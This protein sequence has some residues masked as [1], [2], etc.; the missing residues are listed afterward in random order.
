MKRALAI[1]LLLG[2]PSVCPGTVLESDPPAALTIVEPV[3]LAASSFVTV[4]NGRSI[5][6]RSLFW[7]CLGMAIG[8]MTLASST[9]ELTSIPAL[10]ATFGAASFFVSLA[11]L[12]RP[13]GVDAPPRRVGLEMNWRAAQLVVRF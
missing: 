6:K 3:L 8:T 10:T 11:R 2:T 5:G 7:S 1:L 12:P 13:M 9:S 4:Y